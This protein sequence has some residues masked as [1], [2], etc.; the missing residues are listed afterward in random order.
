[1]EIITNPFKRCSI[2]GGREVLKVEHEEVIET[3]LREHEGK[4]M[5]SNLIECQANVKAENS[6]VTFSVDDK[7]KIHGIKINDG[8]SDVF[9]V[10]KR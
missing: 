6:E 4:L 9:E 7:G 10:C 5:C 8:T 3:N 2:C 1:M